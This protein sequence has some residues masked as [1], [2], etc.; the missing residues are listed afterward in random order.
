MNARSGGANSGAAQTGEAHAGG[1]QSG[2][3]QSG[4]AQSSDSPSGGPRRTG[5]L[6]LT[7]IV[8]FVFFWLGRGAPLTESESGF[9]TT[10]NLDGFRGDAWMLPDD[11]LLGFVEIPAGAFLMGSDP[12][13]DPMAY[14]N[15]RW[16]AARRQGSPELP[17]FYIGRFEVTEAQFQAFAARVDTVAPLSR[18][19]ALPVSGVSWPEALAYGRWLEEQMRASSATPQAIRDA[20]D[21]GWRITLPSEAQWE[22]AARGVDGRI[23]PWGSNPQGGN[24]NFGGGAP[25]DVREGVCARCSHGL[26]DMAGNVWEMTASPLRDYPF[27]VDAAEAG[28]VAGDLAADALFVMRGG[29]YADGA[30]NVRAAVRGAVDP[31]VRNPTIGFRLVISPP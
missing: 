6:A 7:L 30:N 29:S 26:A 9:S 18:V 28:A 21:S 31:G 25:R 27:V 24:A 8:V 19:S 5:L 23:F 4:G 2:H 1:A 13:R 17:T 20:L 14:A 11:E 10:P 16:S 15:E 3:A 12:A 22:K